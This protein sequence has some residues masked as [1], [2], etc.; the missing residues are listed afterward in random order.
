MASQRSEERRDAGG[1]STVM[2]ASNSCM[3]VSVVIKALNEERNIER[4]LKTTLAAIEG[5]NAEVI[6][7]DSMSVDRTVEIAKR[8]P[9]KVV[10]LTNGD[11]RCCGIGAQLGYQ[12]AHGTYVLVIDG[13]M[14]VQGSWLRT[15]IG[16]LQTVTSLAGV[17]GVVADVNVANMEFLARQ[18]RHSREMRPGTVDRLDG[19]G[20]YRRAAI[21]QVGYLTHRSLHACEELELGLRLRSAGWTLER[22][23][24]VSMRHYGHTAP[25][26][27]LVQQR[28]RSRYVNGAGE[29]LR[30][31]LGKPWF[32]KTVASLKF[33]L[34]VLG[35]W[36]VLAL[37]GLAG[38]TTGF[39][40]MSATVALLAP[41]LVMVAR[42]RSVALGLYSVLAWCIDA[43]GMLRGLCT[44]PKDPVAT[45]DSRILWTGSALASERQIW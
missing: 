15:A 25:M 27:T 38:V 43:A 2:T 44:K 6:L 32:W 22:L 28:W 26:W 40:W 24:E 14:E 34:A 3:D 20:L 7:A 5:L 33:R 39:G 30:S 11:E 4:T 19:G 42:K 8:F 17:G 1:D 31:S 13:D 10:Q 36:M 9:V 37:L 29:L 18:K 16:R 35:W 41:P 23:D 12:H 21:D 45:I